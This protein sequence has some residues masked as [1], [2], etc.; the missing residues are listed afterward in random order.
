MNDHST[1]DSKLKKYAALA[2]GITAVAGATNAQVQ[3]TDINPDHLVTGNGDSYSLDLNN[4]NV[5]DFEFVTV[6]GTYSFTYMS[7]PVNMQYD[8]GLIYPGAS[9]NSWMV[10]T[11]D[12]TIANLPAGSSIDPSNVFS[13]G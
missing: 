4:D 1:L 10:N 8:I 2:T 9:S 13:S 11:S 12:T 7:L 3:Y 6:S 5:V